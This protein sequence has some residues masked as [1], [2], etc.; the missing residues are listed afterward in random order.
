[1]EPISSR[2]S[3][4]VRSG[5]PSTNTCSQA[6]R[7]CPRVLGMEGECAH[8]SCCPQLSSAPELAHLEKAGVALELSLTPGQLEIVAAMG[9]EKGEGRA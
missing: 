7:E 9:G 6:G 2:D 1:M 3:S 8:C 5:F 4:G